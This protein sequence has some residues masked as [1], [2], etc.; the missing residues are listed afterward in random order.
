M[1]ARLLG[2]ALASQELGERCTGAMWLTVMAQYR[3]IRWKTDWHCS[4]KK[5]TTQSKNL[6]TIPSFINYIT[7]N[8]IC[9][10]FQTHIEK[11]LVPERTEGVSEWW[12]GDFTPG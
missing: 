8:Y 3:K 2:G 9:Q 10:K 11:N 4:Y 6:I 12:S 1:N 7:I 5:K